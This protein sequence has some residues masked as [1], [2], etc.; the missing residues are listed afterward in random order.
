MYLGEHSLVYSALRAY[1]SHHHLVLRPDDVW[2]AIVTQFSSYVNGNAEALRDKFVDFKGKKQLTVYTSFPFLSAPYDKMAVEMTE[3]IAKNI[4][5]PSIRE[6]VL[7]SFTTTTY[8]DKV[9]GAVSLM[10]TM[11]SYFNYR[12]KSMCGLPRVTL[13][14]SVDDWKEI[15]DR[16]SRLKEFEIKDSD[17]MTQWFNVLDPIIDNFIRSAEGNPDLHWWNQI[18]DQRAGSGF[19]YLSGWIT[20]FSVFDKDGH[21]LGSK[22]SVNTLGGS[23]SSDNNWF[24][25]D[26]DEDKPIGYVSVPITFEEQNGKQ[27]K[28]EMFAGHMS[29]FTPSQT[30]IQ[31]QLSWFYSLLP[32]DNDKLPC[33]PN[34]KFN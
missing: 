8:T 25:L 15:K 22:K 26:L 13:Q 4:K 19:S 21:W 18:V 2:L 14:G 29:A 7:P 10:A 33:T 9:V 31:P 5:D 11:K 1:N 28:T 17:I 3:Q 12:F 23:F 34:P 32:G 30:S 27:H 6:W 20:A 16:V 24:I